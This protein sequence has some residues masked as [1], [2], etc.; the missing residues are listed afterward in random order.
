MVDEDS[1]Q[2]KKGVWVDDKIW[3]MYEP[4]IGAS[5]F[6]FSSPS[7]PAAASHAPPKPQSATPTC[8]S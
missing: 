8:G 1:T 2:T 3:N 5:R 6:L 7:L 4:D